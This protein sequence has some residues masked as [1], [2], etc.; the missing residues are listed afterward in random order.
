M[1]NKIMSILKKK[2]AVDSLSTLLEPHQHHQM[3]MLRQQRTGAVAYCDIVYGADED[4][5][6]NTSTDFHQTI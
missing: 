6:D 3:A 4:D 1:V 2:S 5:L